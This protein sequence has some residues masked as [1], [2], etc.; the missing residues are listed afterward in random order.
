MKE[1][2][3]SPLSRRALLARAGKLIGPRQ[4]PQQIKLRL[5]LDREGT[6][7]QPRIRSRRETNPLTR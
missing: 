7:H 4:I 5:H 6:Q 2:T 3:M 1:G